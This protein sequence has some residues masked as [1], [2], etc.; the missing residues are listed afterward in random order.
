MC[1]AK[2][3]ST[4][5]EFSRA[6]SRLILAAGGCRPVK[7]ELVLKHQDLEDTRHSIPAFAAW[8]RQQ[9][10]R[11]TLA[12]VALHMSPY[13]TKRARAYATDVR[14]WWL[15]YGRSG[16]IRVLTQM[17]LAAWE[18]LQCKIE[19]RTSFRRSPI[20]AVIISWCISERHPVRVNVMRS[21]FLAIVFV[22]LLASPL[23]AQS[24]T[25]DR[26]QRILDSGTLRVGTIMLSMAHCRAYA[27][28][29]AVALRA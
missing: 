28:A 10:H 6:R 19:L 4:P 18:F 22:V 9:G 3:A 11:L 15:T 14:S 5:D 13:G 16:G 1:I 7:V 20:P 26:L 12:F 29:S 21:Q 23:A 27:T 24:P 25:A 17:R 2:L 8:P